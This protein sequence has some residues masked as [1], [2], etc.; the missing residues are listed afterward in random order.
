LFA[1]P[2]RSSACFSK[3]RIWPVRIVGNGVN[4][5][6]VYYCSRLHP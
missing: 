3:T 2:A 5:A 6:N 1:N 4:R